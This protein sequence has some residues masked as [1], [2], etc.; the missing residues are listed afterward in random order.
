MASLRFLI[1]PR[2]SAMSEMCDA[3]STV[4]GPCSLGRW[5]NNV[6]GNVFV[7]FAYVNLV[8]FVRSG[9]IASD[10]EA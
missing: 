7:N 2:N 9:A 1:L 8:K 4:N 10:D 3:S 5:M 6:D